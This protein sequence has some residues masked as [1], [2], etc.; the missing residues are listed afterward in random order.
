M[1]GTAV[2]TLPD[3][4]TLSETQRKVLRILARDSNQVQLS[5]NGQAPVLAGANALVRKG[6][7]GRGNASHYYLC[8]HARQYAM[9]ILQ[10]WR[11]ERAAEKKAA[12]VAKGES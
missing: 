9:D 3:P 1:T 7:V 8:N 10:A 6:L 11:V 2:P 4:K 5:G 12:E